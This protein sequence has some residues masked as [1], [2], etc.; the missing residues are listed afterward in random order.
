MRSIYLTNVK[1][2]PILEKLAEGEQKLA[3][4]QEILDKLNSEKQEAERIC[5]ELND[6]A[7]ECMA[8]KESVANNLMLNKQ[9]LVRAT[10]LLSGFKDEKDRWTIDVQQLQQN[11]EFIVGNCLLASGV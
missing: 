9:R 2:K 1:L 4:G 8:R 10:K 3:E 5:K 6:E 11:L 7:A